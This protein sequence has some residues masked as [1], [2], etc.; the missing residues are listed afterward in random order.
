MIAYKKFQRFLNYRQLLDMLL[1]IDI[2]LYNGYNLKE[3]YIF[4]NNSSSDLEQKLD[5]LINDFIKANIP[6]FQEF[7]GLLQH[8]RIEILNSFCMLHGKRINN[9]VAES[10][11]S[12]VK[13]VL[14]NSKGI[15]NSERRRKRIMYAI[16]KSGF[17]IK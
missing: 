9:S 1:S 5:S 2:D 11:N 15:R 7:V 8:W 3:R 13:L 12:Q 17:L 4:F 14:Y 16:N 6:E 10:L